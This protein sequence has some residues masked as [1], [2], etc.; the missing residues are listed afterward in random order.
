MV[1]TTEQHTVKR[2]NISLV[3]HYIKDN[4]PV[5]RVE[6]AKHLGL[7]KATV[8][9]IVQE[10]INKGLVYEMGP[11]ASSGGRKPVII[12]FNQQCAYSIGVDVKVGYVQGLLVDFKGKV[13]Q[14][15]II[16]YEQEH[17]SKQTIINIVKKTIYTLLEATPPSLYGVVGISIGV[18][19]IV[20]C[21]GF[22]LHAPN[23]NW[24][25]VDIQT[26]LADEF[27][28]PVIVDNDSNFGAIAEYTF[29]KIPHTNNFLYVSV[30]VG[31]GAGI[32]INGQLYK[33][34]FGFSG[35][36]GHMTIVPDGALCSCGNKGCW[37][38]YASE[39][40]LHKASN[41]LNSENLG[42]DDLVHLA[43][44]GDY[45]VIEL[46]KEMGEYFGIGL[47]NLVNIFNPESIVIGSSLNKLS[48]WIEPAIYREMETRALVY[49]RRRFHIS[50]S[51]LNN[52][53]TCLGGSL[54]AI[55]TFCRTTLNI[56]K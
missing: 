48:K 5:S 39:K 42:I 24:K 7:T 47:S 27:N 4:S 54:Q 43:N 6:I 46:F 8:S 36:V 22:I 31:I 49:H 30:G 20:D 45:H 18:P 17:M 35:E 12:V 53:A 15:E 51:H 55:E 9:T 29:G 25:D 32:I 41:R 23:L 56:I 38:L 33:G 10:L 19:G 3:F 40:A 11:G 28:I 34:S 16:T 26:I 44:K 52:D 50:F 1:H 37:E 21:D 14:K 13:V 2:M